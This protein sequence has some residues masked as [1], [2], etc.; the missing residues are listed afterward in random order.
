MQDGGPIALV[1]DGDIISIDAEARTM[2]ME[3]SDAEL[4]SRHNAWTAPPLKSKQGTL[5]KYIKSVGTAS[6]GCITDA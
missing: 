2:E 3:V 6:E 4:T 5:Y 1:Q